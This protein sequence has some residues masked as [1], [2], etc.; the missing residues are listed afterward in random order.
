V[1]RFDQRTPIGRKSD[2]AKLIEAVLPTDVR[3]KN[4]ARR[5]ILN[6]Y[7][8]TWVLSEFTVNDILQ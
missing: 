6:D 2:L 8:Q 4:I 1:E 7:L 3:V 5:K